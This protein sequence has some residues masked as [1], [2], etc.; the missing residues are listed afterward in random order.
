MQGIAG[1]VCL[2]I[3]VLNSMLSYSWEL[4]KNNVPSQALSFRAKHPQN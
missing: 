2:V 4:P 3:V 1:A